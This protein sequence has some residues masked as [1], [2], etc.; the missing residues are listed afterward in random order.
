[1]NSPTR[2]DAVPPATIRAAPARADT[3]LPR[4][5]GL[6][7][8]PATTTW[9]EGTI[10]MGGS[11]LRLLRLS[12]RARALVDGWQAGSLVGDR[13]SEQVLARRLVS[14]G[15]FV[16]RPVAP[17]SGP[18][19]VTVVV[20]VRDRPAQLQHLLESL[21]GLSLVV[22]DDGSAD[23]GRTEK[24]ARAAGAT[25]IALPKNLGPAAARNAGLAVAT[26]PLVAFVD[27]DCRPAPGWLS[28]LLGYFDDPLVAAVAPRIVPAPT[29]PTTWISRYEAVRSSLDRGTAEGVVRPQ[30]RISYVPSAALVV[31]REVADHP[32]FD[33]ALRGGEDVDLVWRLVAAGWDVRY[34]P[35]TTVAHRGPDRLGSWLGRRHFYGTTAGPLARRHPAEMAPLH[36]SVWPAAVWGLAAARRPVLAGAALV[37]SIVVLARRLGG[38]VEQPTKVATRIAGGGTARSALPA[39]G[40][41][42][43]AW[44]PAFV[45]GLLSRR[46]R[47]ACALALLLPAA[48]DWTTQPG[49]LDPV[50]YAALHVADDL[51]YGSGVWRGCLQA[52][53]IRPL[54]PRVSWRA[55]VWS[56]KSLRSGL[57]TGQPSGQAST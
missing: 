52:R 43:R 55:R 21:D 15:L 26:T 39:L 14:S 49:E 6:A 54:L 35:S 7:L 36:T 18:R 2:D 48:H 38:L 1:M 40:G 4:G 3:P 41:L 51:A 47:R 57:Q 19:D 30:S 34:A 10:L 31:R 23:P 20:P 45:A 22:V 37:A 25:F 53:T 12:P 56:T 50:R 9:Q 13:R 29:F 33:P 44:S 16:L 8:D 42:T 32:F 28:A 5:F 11:P 46:T 24:I 17:T 27:S